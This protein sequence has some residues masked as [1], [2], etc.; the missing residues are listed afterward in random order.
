MSTTYKLPIMNREGRQCDPTEIIRQIGTMNIFA[1][2]GG[3]WGSLR[4][5]EHP[6]ETIG[7]WLPCG[8]A[9]MVE[10]TLDFDDTYRVRRVRRVTR[11]SQRDHAIV[12]SEVSGIYCDQV[13]EVAYSASC[14]R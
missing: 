11:G 10:I 6:T 9:R 12:E 13:G 4:N 14:W 7:V 3:R 2:S 8:V 5:S 1:I